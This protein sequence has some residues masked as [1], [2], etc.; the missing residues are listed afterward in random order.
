MEVWITN[1]NEIGNEEELLAIVNQFSSSE[2]RYC[3]QYVFLEDKIRS[4]LSI[5]LQRA[6]IRDV[7]SVD[8][9]NYT[10]CRTREVVYRVLL[11]VVSRF[12]RISHLFG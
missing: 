2:S 12:S 5:L 11:L 3:L 9:S 4:A 7:F 10:I 1:K 6:M 8:E